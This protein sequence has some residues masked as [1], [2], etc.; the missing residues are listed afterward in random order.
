[1][2]S[3]RCVERSE[4]E[5]ADEGNRTGIG[6]S[7]EQERSGT[8]WILGEWLWQLLRDEL[9]GGQRTHGLAYALLLDYLECSYGTACELRARLSKFSC[10]GSFRLFPIA[11]AAF[12]CMGSSMRGKENR[13][14]LWLCFHSV[15]LEIDKES[16][17]FRNIWNESIFLELKRTKR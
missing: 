13:F 9:F 15:M 4:I 16:E 12:L 5:P 3:R 1:M 17:N 10:Q 7:V 6:D 14:H 8:Q 2:C 11:T